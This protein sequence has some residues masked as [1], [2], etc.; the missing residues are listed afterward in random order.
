MGDISRHRDIFLN[1]REG[2]PASLLDK[3]KLKR[4]DLTY[5]EMGNYLTD[6]SQFR[7][8]VMY[9]FSK[10]RVW[11]DFIIPKAGD[12]AMAYRAVAA[13]ASVASAAVATQ[14]SDWISGTGGKVAAGAAGVLA[15]AAGVLAL[16]PTDTFADIGGADE[17]I[18]QM[19]GTPIE[20]TIGDLKQRDEKHYGYVGQFFQYA[21]EGMTQLL[22]AQDVTNKVKGD[23]GK[24]D[25]IPDASVQSVFKEFFTQYYPHEHTDQ[26][27]YTWDASRRPEKEDWYGPGKR[28]RNLID[29]EVGVMNAVDKHYVQ[30]LSEGLAQLQEE[31][32]KIKPDDNTARHKWLVRMGKLLH[33]VEDWY[34]H[35]NVVELIRMRAHRP[36]Q[37]ETEATEDFLK[38]FVT[39][40]AGKDPEFILADGPEKIRL[41]RR[42]YRRLRFPVYERGD[43]I[44]SGGT[45]SKTKKSTPSLHHAYPAFPSQQ[46]TAHTLMHALENLE[47]KTRHPSA[48]KSDS[49]ILPPWAPCVLGKFLSAHG[50]PGEKL[51]KE[52]AAARGIQ[53]ATVVAAIV[54]GGPE[55]NKAMAVV[56]DVM[57]EWVPL[58]VTLL[59]E[60]ERQRLVA[61]TAPL[62]WPLGKP[63][64]E[65]L[66]GKPRE[67]I[68]MTNQLKRHADALEPQMHEDGIKENN[69]ER[70]IRYL[71]DCGFINDAGKDALLKS[72]AIDHKS[73]K[74][75]EKAPGAGGFL[76]QFSIELQSA[77]DK[78]DAA[79]EKLNQ[80]KDSIQEQLSDNGAFNEIIGSHSLM[81]KDTLTSPPF[82]DD[83]KVLAS[84]AS[85]TVFHVMLEQ[86][87]TPVAGKRLPWKT[88]LHRL[89]RYPTTSGG[90]E[91][92]AMAFFRAPE[93]RGKIPRYT[94]IPELTGLV[95]TALE[96]REAGQPFEKGTKDDD[97]KNEYIALE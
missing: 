88:L 92:T 63:T 7:D 71:R 73:Q 53:T 94:D 48:P 21:I 2:I 89:I 50:G 3:C 47:F 58:I 40:T 74:L 22:F 70:A 10:Q 4:N 75:L 14:V 61:D 44:N 33:G 93:N 24:L 64:A 76:I 18:D 60:G 59:D 30:Y 67:G 34:F 62:D 19:F 27:P 77:L 31:W 87:G 79:T 26:P 65:D 1:T 85:S 49:G 51:L 28:Q 38:R 17:W 57:R 12:K 54:A 46:D 56:I 90:W 69:Y 84:V 15:G 41:Q 72:F 78:G 23:W 5:L 97:L 39:E 91:R 11:R 16:L 29:K 9:I 13:L 35:S 55:R 83:A 6:V 8:P 43:K 37:G 32:K 95:R 36:A 80:S 45:L 20:L 25:R 86:V 52:K 42:L 96:S 68:E 82:F 66:K 81:S